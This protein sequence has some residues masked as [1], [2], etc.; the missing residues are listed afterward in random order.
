MICIHCRDFKKVFQCICGRSDQEIV[1]AEEA[2]EES[3]FVI[4][5]LFL[6]VIAV[7]FV[8]GVGL[9][10]ELLLRGVY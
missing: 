6:G 9:F 2:Q 8:A 4:A 5:L 7:L 1:A 10:Y 3:A